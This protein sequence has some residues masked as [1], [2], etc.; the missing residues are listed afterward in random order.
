MLRGELLDEPEIAETIIDLA[1]S[2][3]LNGDDVH[4]DLVRLVSHP[5]CEVR[6]EAMGALAYHGV[7]FRWEVGPGQ[8]VA[9][10]SPAG[11]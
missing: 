7:S 2:D 1:R 11:S 3:L 4:R 10:P 6:S 8:A 9:A 5:D